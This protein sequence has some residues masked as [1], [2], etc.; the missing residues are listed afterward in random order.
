MSCDEKGSN[1]GAFLIGLLS[2]AAIGAGLALLFAPQS[3]KETR[4]KI[5]DV[6]EDV[7]DKISDLIDDTKDFLSEQKR[8]LKDAVEAGKE[9][10]K[11]AYEGQE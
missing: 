10:I 2:G 3:G 5:K 11:R 8:A 6:A 1:F 4:D 7:K 9:A